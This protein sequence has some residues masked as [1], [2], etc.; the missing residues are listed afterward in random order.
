MSNTVILYG[1]DTGNTEAAAK[2]IASRL[3][4]DIFDVANTQA[5]KLTE[6]DNLILGTSTMGLGDLQDDWASFISELEKTDLTDKTIALFGLGDADMYP[7]SFV[8]GMGEIYNTV[9]DKGCKIVGKVETDGYEFDESF[10]VVDGVFIGLP[11]DE[12]NQSDLTDERI[13]SWVKKIRNE[14]N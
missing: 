1:S 7:D 11:L 3:E 6:Y 5:N 14:F 2:K 9:K 4:A 8:D 10:A 12:D 13:E